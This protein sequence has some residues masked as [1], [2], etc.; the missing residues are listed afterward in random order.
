MDVARPVANMRMPIY[1]DHASDRS[2]RSCKTSSLGRQ[3][4]HSPLTVQLL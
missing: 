2:E 1:V 4:K 3:Y